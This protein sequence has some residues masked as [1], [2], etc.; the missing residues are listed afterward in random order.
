MARNASNLSLSRRWG[1]RLHAH[2]GGSVAHIS[3]A[4]VW[5]ITLASTGTDYPSE[6]E[7]RKF[8][9]EM[10]SGRW[11]GARATAAKELDLAEW[12]EAIRKAEQYG[13]RADEVRAVLE[14]S[15]KALLRDQ[16]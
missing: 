2:G 7:F 5:N 3:R 11:K 15:E 13:I 8:W 16:A 9:D 6:R 4:T 10:W 1:C 14:G 12:W